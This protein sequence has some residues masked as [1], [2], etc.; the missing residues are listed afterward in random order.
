MIN[1]ISRDGKSMKSKYIMRLNSVE[2][3]APE[4]YHTFILA[5]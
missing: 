4:T 5:N 2:S 1:T 3:G